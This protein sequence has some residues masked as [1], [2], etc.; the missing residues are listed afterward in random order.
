[1][2]S[3][4]LVRPSTPSAPDARPLTDMAY[5]GVRSWLRGGR[6][7]NC[8]SGIVSKALTDF[9]T[10]HQLTPPRIV[11]RTHNSLN[12]VVE[13]PNAYIEGDHEMMLDAQ[14]NP[15]GLRRRSARI[16]S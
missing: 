8:Q 16:S 14:R 2:R 12:G 5:G 7:Q 1:M 6:S 11:K 15:P 10:H 13:A 9:V 4:G 3:L